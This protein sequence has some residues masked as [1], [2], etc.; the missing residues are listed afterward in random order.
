M[1]DQ[2]QGDTMI[3]YI[4]TRTKRKTIAIYIRDGFVEVRAPHNAPVSEIDRFV[5]SKEKWIADRLAEKKQQSAQKEGFTLAYGD[6]LLYHGKLHPIR[7]KP[8]DMA[9]FN[10][11]SFY[12]PTDL[13][14]A[15][16]KFYC[17][18]T[19]RLLAERDL[20]ERAYELMDEMD[21]DP[22]SIRISNAKRVWG[23]CSSTKSINFSWRLVMAD[24][25]VI[26]Y[27]IVHELAHI[28]EPNHSKQFWAIVEYYI[29]DYKERRARLKEL[30]RKLR[31]EDWG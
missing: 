11:L 14:P 28:I 30:E 2:N 18:K 13:T 15:E 7:G 17:K 1:P 3:E 21:V 16:I 27:V 19:Y 10:V 12:M 6:M 5:I 9:G 25:D 24:E 22:A 4:L 23:S 29:P 20:T 26:D 8:G 31:T